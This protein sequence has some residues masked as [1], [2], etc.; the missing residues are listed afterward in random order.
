VP[1]F[2]D[3]NKRDVSLPPGC[4][5]LIDLLKPGLLSAAKDLVDIA[6]SGLPP[7]VKDLINLPISTGNPDF[8]R[9][10]DRF[11]QGTRHR[12][13]ATGPISDLPHHVQTL[14]ASPALSHNL[15]FRTPDERLTASLSRM[16]LRTV[17]ASVTVEQKTD[18]ERAVLE[19]LSNRG[20]EIPKNAGSPATFLIDAPELPVYLICRISPLPSDSKEVAQLLLDLFRHT[21]LTNETVIRYDRFEVLESNPP[22]AE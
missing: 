8:D 3:Y 2:V 4:K 12:E 22:L 18:T 14:F 15:W 1:D 19:F 9:L 17:T 21:G 5:D 10:L 13:S 6:K 16:L 20:L 11:K 7:N